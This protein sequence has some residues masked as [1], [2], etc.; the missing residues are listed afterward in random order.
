MTTYSVGSLLSVPFHLV[1]IPLGHSQ[2]DNQD[3]QPI[4]AE[5]QNTKEGKG[6][7]RQHRTF[8]INVVSKNTF[9][10]AVFFVFCDS[11]ADLNSFIQLLM[12]GF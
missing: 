2:K 10:S 3:E 12:C 9:G 4:E 1:S 7:R 6:V 5:R 11:L 8:R